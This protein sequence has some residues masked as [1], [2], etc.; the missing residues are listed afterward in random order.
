MGKAAAFHPIHGERRVHTSMYHPV[1]WP[2]NAHVCYVCLHNNMSELISKPC[3]GCHKLVLA[4]VP[5][6]APPL[7]GPSHHR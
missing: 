6:A 4:T 2:R 3:R 5:L 7:G 1:S